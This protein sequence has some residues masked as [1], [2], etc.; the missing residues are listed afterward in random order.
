MWTGVLRASVAVALMATGTWGALRLA[1]LGARAAAADIVSPRIDALQGTVAELGLTQAG[2]IA[3][4]HDPTPSLD[5]AS[6]L[7]TELPA[8]TAQ[9]APS[10]RSPE[11]TR[12]LQA[13]A[14]HA[15][16]LVQ[17]DA[18][19]R[20]SVLIGDIPTASQEIFGE[21]RD[22]LVAMYASLRTVRTAEADAAQ[23]ERASA[24]GEA[25]RTLL[26]VGAAWVIGMLVLVPRSLSRRTVRKAVPEAAPA[27]GTE[28]PAMAA[29]IDAT[30]VADLCM[31]VARVVTP[32]DLETLLRRSVDVLGA[33]AVTLSVASGNE[34]V[35]VFAYPDDS[36]APVGGVS[37]SADHGGARAFRRG[38]IQTQ[39]ADAGSPAALFAPLVGPGGCSG[40]LAVTLP[41]GRESDPLVRAMTVTLAAQLSTVVTGMSGAAISASSPAPASVT[42]GSRP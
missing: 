42:A 23:R 26:G 27:A 8:A 6:V 36:K 14:D 30:A 29:S 9:I 37:R 7:L 10:V 41:S 11:G 20:E 13:F 3:L 22:A 12:A 16:A 15:S 40:V 18:R 38:A 28:P 25:R 35:A 21:S 5:R 1:D 19:T 24:L 32:A 2:Y 31:G 33:S 39:P 17:S 34:L 4:G